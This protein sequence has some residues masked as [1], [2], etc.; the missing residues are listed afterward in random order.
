MNVL[1]LGALDSRALADE[2]IAATNTGGGEVTMVW[3]QSGASR[4]AF[5]VRSQPY[6]LFYDAAGNEITSR[7]GVIDTELLA[8]LL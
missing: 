5:G 3:E 8:S 6:W 4:S 2:F 1:G 7:P